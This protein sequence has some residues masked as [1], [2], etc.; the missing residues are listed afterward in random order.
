MATDSYGPKQLIVNEQNGLLTTVDDAEALAQAMQRILS[1]P[2]LR[3]SLALAGFESVRARFSEAVVV[4]AYLEFF[5]RIV[6]R[7]NACV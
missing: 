1:Q 5:E 3:Q 4:E 2:E 7:A 6:R